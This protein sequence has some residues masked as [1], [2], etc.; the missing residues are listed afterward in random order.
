MLKEICIL[1]F[2]GLNTWTDIRRKEISL[3]AAAVF[4]A[5]SLIWTACTGRISTSFFIPVGIS[6]F[7]L[8][9]SIVTKGALGMGDGWLMMALGIAME[10]E[11]FLVMLLIGLGCSAIWAGI[12]LVILHNGRKAEIPFVPF[13][14]LGYIGGVL[15]WK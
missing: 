7:F 4:A 1:G 12:L 3:V 15:L 14:F 13:L 8:V 5:G 11:E 10:T 9:V 2:L 6:A